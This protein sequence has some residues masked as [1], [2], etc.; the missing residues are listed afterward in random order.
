MIVCRCSINEMKLMGRRGDHSYQEL[1]HMIVNA[2]YEL[3]E[4]E[5][6]SKIST[7]KIA[8]SI[9]YTVGTLYNI[10]SNIDDI[11]IHVNSLTIDKLYNALQAAVE[12]GPTK[13]NK[14]KAL[15]DAYIKFSEENFNLWSVL[16]EYR[17]PNE[18]P[19]PKW[20]NA[21]ISKMYS[22]VAEAFKSVKPDLTEDKVRDAVM[23]LWSCMHGICAL[24][25]KG[26][27]DRV[28]AQS[29]QVLSDNFIENYL[30][31]LGSN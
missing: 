7:R 12:H 22:I 1:N 16:F 25:I 8:T 29:A 21:K 28:G 31:G 5:G 24:S 19:I 20:Y 27:L 17:L 3:M 9:G 15:A 13:V 18:Q 6:H 30:K 26:K 14:L 23:V 10:F 2:A 4:N 11:Y